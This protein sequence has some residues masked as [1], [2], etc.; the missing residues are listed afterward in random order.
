MVQI[1]QRESIFCRK[2]SSGGVLIYQKISSGGNQ[3][4]GVHFYHDSPL[5]AESLSHNYKE[6]TSVGTKL[7][8]SFLFPCA[9][10]IVGG[11]LGWG[12]P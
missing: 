12:V 8:P 2:I 5:A 10:L 6:H 9:I 7:Y 11:M 3:F 4:G 1:F